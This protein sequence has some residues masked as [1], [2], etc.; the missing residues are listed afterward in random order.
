MI[1]H[2]LRIIK[3][4]TRMKQTLKKSRMGFSMKNVIYTVSNVSSPFLIR[5]G[6]QIIGIIHIVKQCL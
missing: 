3:K 2:M 1:S 6:W 5:D 4:K